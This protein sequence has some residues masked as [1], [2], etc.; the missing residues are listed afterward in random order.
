MAGLDGVNKR[1]LF[2]QVT[3]PQIR[4]VINMVLVY[5]VIDCFK[6]YVLFQSSFQNGIMA[7][8]T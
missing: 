3:L 5:T 4:P 1:Q 8:K 2:F 6:V 7:T